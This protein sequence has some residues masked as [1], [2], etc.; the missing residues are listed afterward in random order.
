[1]ITHDV[2]K[3]IYKREYYLKKKI[4]SFEEKFD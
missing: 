1:M 4:I 2:T 3:S